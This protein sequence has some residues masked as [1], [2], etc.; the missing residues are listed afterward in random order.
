MADKK[1]LFDRIGGKAAIQAAVDIFYDK[2]TSDDLIKHFFNGVDIKTQK[3]KQRAFLAYAFG[4]PVKYTGK[5][6]RTAHAKLEGI[7]E[8]HFNDI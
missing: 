3:A 1:T 8:D 6:M 5:D 4:G 7:N 2:V